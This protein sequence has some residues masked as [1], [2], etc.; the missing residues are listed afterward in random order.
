[1]Y[2]LIAKYYNNLISFFAK[3]FI[4]F[5]A[6]YYLW[7]H[8]Y[9]NYFL[10][11]V[12]LN[13]TV[14]LVFILIGFSLVNWF[15]E[16]KKWKF[17]ASQLQNIS[18]VEAVK[19]SLISFSI[20]LLTPNRFGEYGVKVLFYPKELY[21]KV[22]MLNLIGNLSQLLVSIL[23]GII[24]CMVWFFS[25]HQ[26]LLN[27]ISI[28]TSNYLFFIFLFIL[29]AALYF[30]FIYGRNLVINKLHVWSKSFLYAGLK[31][32]VFSTQFLILILFF[33]PQVNMSFLYSGIF[34]VYFISALVPMLAFLDWAVKS[35]V[36][37]WVLAQIGLPESIV[38]TTVVLMWLTNFL[39]PF[40]IGLSMMWFYKNKGR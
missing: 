6:V 31:Y 20:S 35:S 40:L 9:F 36:A 19:Q 18:F 23:M 25:D 28:F 12:K 3:L 11:E 26:I 5:W 16:V 1:M 14:K 32:A 34:I 27:K 29:L 17:L 13:S 4:S 15:F 8:H 2:K 10:K 39:L 24:G 37:I 30:K 38:F 21:K 33:Y 7:Y 22:L